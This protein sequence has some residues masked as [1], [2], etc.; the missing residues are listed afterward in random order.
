[1]CS[2]A[3]IISKEKDILPHT[4]TFEL[5]DLS[6]DISVCTTRYIIVIDKKEILCNVGVGVGPLTYLL[7]FY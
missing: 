7:F 1:M 3:M 2:M 4:L 5:L 6:K